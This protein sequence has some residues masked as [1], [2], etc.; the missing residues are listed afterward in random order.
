MSTWTFYASWYGITADPVRD[1]LG[2]G[3][4]RGPRSATRLLLRRAYLA[5][6]PHLARAGI[7]PFLHFLARRRRAGRDAGKGRPACRGPTPAEAERLAR[8]LVDGAV[9]PRRQPRPRRRPASTRPRTTWPRAGARAASRRPSSTPWPT[10]SPA[11]SPSPPR[12]RWCTT[13]CTAD[14]PGPTRTRALALRIETLAPYFDAAHYRQAPGRAA[15]RGPGRRRGRRDCC[16]TT[17]RR[18]GRRG[19]ARGRTSTRPATC[20]RASGSRAVA[21]RP[22]LPHRG[23]ERGS[24]GAEPFAEPHRLNLPVV[25]A[26]W[27]RATYPDAGGR[28]PYPALRR[29]GLAGAARSGAG[30]LDAGGAAAGLRAAAGAGAGGGHRLAGGDRAGAPR[31]GRAPGPAGA[32]GGGAFRSRLLPGALRA[33]GGGGRGAR[34]LRHRLEEGP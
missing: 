18:A 25:D 9:L 10:A 20:R 27:Y 24:T 16:A 33:V 11:A 31:P 23:R 22:V 15:G 2:A 4:A 30:A 12:T 19:S 5:R 3:L 32:A 1:Y 34:L 8:R 17:W 14:P 7:N 29:G 6:H 13:S 21:R 28:E 26:D